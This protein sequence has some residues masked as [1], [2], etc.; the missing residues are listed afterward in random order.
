MKFL[1]RAIII[2]LSLVTWCACSNDDAPLPAYQFAL[3]DLTSDLTGTAYELSLDDGTSPTLTTAISQLK[4][5]TTY[6]IQ[7]AYVLLHD[8]RAQV[9]SYTPILAPQVGKYNANVAYA[10]PLSVVTCWRTPN[11][12]NLQLNIKGTAKGVHYFGFNETDY[13]TN[14]DGTH[15][16]CISLIHNQNNDPLYYTR[17]A[18][19]SLPLRPLSQLLRTNCDSIQLSI[20]TFS[21]IEKYGFKF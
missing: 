15:T 7:A 3:A 10:H 8:G 6:R 19:L 11:Y 4:P 18:Y 14:A 16:M 5:D 9:N 20:N 21:G 2:A 1:Y 12:I 13:R 17:T